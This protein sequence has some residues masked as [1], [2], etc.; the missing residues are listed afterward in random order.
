MQKTFPPLTSPSPKDLRTFR[1]H[2]HQSFPILPKCRTARRLLRSKRVQQAF[3]LMMALYSETVAAEPNNPRKVPSK[4]RLTPPTFPYLFSSVF[5]AA[6]TTFS[7][8]F[9][10]YSTRCIYERQT[11]YQAL[12]SHLPHR[13]CQTTCRHYRLQ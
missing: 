13:S 3:A 2:F 6:S 12:G 4:L 1:G 7:P 5:F 9:S 10:H 8:F 11:Y